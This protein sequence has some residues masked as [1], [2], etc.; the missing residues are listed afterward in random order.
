MKTD[1]SQE[2]YLDVQPSLLDQLSTDGSLISYHGFVSDDPDSSDSYK[3]TFWLAKR[4]GSKREHLRNI[5]NDRAF[6]DITISANFKTAAYRELDT[7]NIEQIY[8]ARGSF[9]TGTA[10]P[11][12]TAN[13]NETPN[14]E[15]ASISICP[16]EAALIPGGQRQFSATYLNSEGNIVSGPATNWQVEGNGSISTT[17]LFTAG[18]KRKK[19]EL[20]QIQASVSNGNGDTVTGTA[21]A[22]I[23]GKEFKMPDLELED[24][25]CKPGNISCETFSLGYASTDNQVGLSAKVIDHSTASI[26]ASATSILRPGEREQTASRQYVYRRPNGKPEVKKA[27]PSMALEQGVN[28]STGEFWVKVCSCIRTPIKIRWSA[29]EFGQ[30]TTSGDE[31][32]APNGIRT[33]GMLESTHY[34]RNDLLCPSIIK[35]AISPISFRERKKLQKHFNKV[36]N[37]KI[38]HF[39]NK[40]L[41]F[42]VIFK[43]SYRRLDKL[44]AFIDKVMKR[45]RWNYTRLQWPLENCSYYSLTVSKK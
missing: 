8:A 14:S 44:E 4:D 36:G 43:K 42:S 33:G 20:V 39:R 21:Y 29:E 35:F 5:N 1:L 23:S 6:Y 2:S 28:S 17:G 10:E 13:P 22:T 16:K 30:G 37:M 40:R 15:I 12:P 24:L 19:G 26:Y 45:N 9:L 18:K 3:E 38:E 11:T 25:K 7:N 32:E 31:C 41:Q 27:S 34:N